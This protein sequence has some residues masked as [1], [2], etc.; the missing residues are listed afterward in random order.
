[1]REVSWSI[2]LR[3]YSG[4]RGILWAGRVGGGG[5]MEMGE[6]LGFLL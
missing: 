6:F 5:E 3:Y 2:R 1:L 4:E